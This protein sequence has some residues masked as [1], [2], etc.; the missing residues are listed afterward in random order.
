MR[1]DI[2]PG[3]IFPDF[4]L[5]DHTEKLCRVPH[6]NVALSATLGWDSR[7]AER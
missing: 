4:E 7:A 5:R 1:S 3:G 6:S 2:V